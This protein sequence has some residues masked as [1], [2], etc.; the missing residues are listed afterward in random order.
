MIAAWVL[1]EI[2]HNGNRF[3]FQTVA[4]PNGNHVLNFTDGKRTVQGLLGWQEVSKSLAEST[5][6]RKKR[7]LEQIGSRGRFR[8]SN[9][10]R[11]FPRTSMNPVCR[12]FFFFE[13]SHRRLF[14]T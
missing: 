4:V 9:K 3:R 7:P 14:A 5:A 10:G 13:E 6:A 1:L 12:A 2:S 8:V 11:R